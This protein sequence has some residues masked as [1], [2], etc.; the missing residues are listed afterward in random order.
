MYELYFEDFPVGAGGECAPHL[1][2][3]EEII[4]FAREF[5]PQPFH[6]SEEAAKGTFV[7][8]L[9]ASGWHTC[10]LTM[11]II[12]D[13][14]LSRS[15]SMGAPGIEEVKWLKPVRPGDTLTARWSIL[16]T[17]LSRSRPRMGLG[18]VRVV[19]F[20]QRD[21]TAYDMSYWMMAERR[22]AAA[23]GEASEATP[24]NAANGAT[25]AA[26]SVAGNPRPQAGSASTDNAGY[27]E[28]LVVGETN[29]AGSYEFTAQNI[30]R[31]AKAFDPQPFHVDPLAAAKS[32][33]GGLCASGWHTGSAC[34]R[35]LIDRR[36]AIRERL[37]AQGEK[38]PGMGSSPGFKNLVWH[39]P[40]YAGDTVDF[41]TTLV[42]KR[43]SASRPGWGI[44]FSRNTGTNQKGELV[45]EFTGSVFIERRG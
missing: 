5:D 2:T 40:V 36:Q 20:N 12:Y 23:S 39:K 1:V 25:A 7:G 9:I 26:A 29:P 16:E 3:R 18:R 34:M 38:L 8:E 43:E 24:A 42:S 44:I 30:I 31:F 17:R 10:S 45:Y 33:F 15:A 35:K 32:H 19:L 6:L 4:A 13:C 11:R 27:F 21:E 22:G 14:F 28:D 37:K 41:A